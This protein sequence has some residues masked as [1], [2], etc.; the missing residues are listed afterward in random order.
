M[1][2][3][4]RQRQS[5][6]PPWSSIQGGIEVRGL[7]GQRD[8]KLPLPN[9]ID[10]DIHPDRPCSWRDRKMQEPFIDGGTFVFHRRHGGKLSV[11]LNDLV[12]ADVS[13]AAL[14]LVHNL[15][16]RLS[17]RELGNIPTAGF[18][19]LAILAGFCSDNPALNE[20]VDAGFA[21]VIAATDQEG[22]F[23]ALNG[24]CRRSEPAG[25][26][27]AFEKRVHQALALEAIHVH[28]ARQRAACRART[29]G[30][31]AGFPLAVVCAFKVGEEEVVRRAQ[32]GRGQAG[33]GQKHNGSQRFHE[34]D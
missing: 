13:P 11:R 18:K 34:R 3:F 26:A 25:G 6:P 10:T 2:L 20:Q 22:E 16:G 23:L 29:E 17:S 5:F 24:E 28:L 7:P 14:V 33:E 27:V 32:P 31:A 19:L 21:L 15:E 4:G 30:F 12:D 8:R 9:T 1:H